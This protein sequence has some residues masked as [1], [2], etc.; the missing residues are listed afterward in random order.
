MNQNVTGKAVDWWS[1]GI[2]LFE[3]L[4]GFSPFYS[5]NNDQMNLFDKI[6]RGK[7]KFPSHFSN[8]AKD[9]IQNI[10]QVD[11]TKR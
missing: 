6:I 7:F 4:A 5:N 1:Y 9:L 11:I 10:L 2:L 8:D 3:F